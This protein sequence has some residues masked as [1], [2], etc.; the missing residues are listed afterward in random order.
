MNSVNKTLYIPLYGKSYV[1]KKGLFII[2]KKAEEIWKKEGFLLKGKAKSKWLAYY[3]GI[4]A[5]VFDEWLREQ[6]A[7]MPDAVVIH[8]G[9]GLD[10]RIERVK[11]D[12]HMWF[13]VDF[14]EVIK[15][16]NRYYTESDY[17]KMISGDIRDS[18]WLRNI[19]E[20]KTAII[21]MEGVSMYLS[22]NEIHNL[23][24]SLCN[25]FENLV[26]LVDSYSTFGAKM[27]KY[28]N[29]VKNVGVKEV[30]GINGPQDYQTEKLAFV[31]EYLMIPQ[32]YK[33]E[34]K[35]IEKFIFSK[36]YAGSFSKKLYRLFEFKKK[37][38]NE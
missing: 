34:L 22:S 16:R 33:D 29:P 18:N 35:G 11:T 30:Y 7:N 24:N 10:S 1:S 23:T 5:A 38:T 31:K 4:R 27:S 15:E 17:Y 19:K 20:N 26:F 3:M 37:N 2:D 36:L 9:C 8:I 28:K 14:S 13:D 6:M 12:N 32:K 25:H 21:V